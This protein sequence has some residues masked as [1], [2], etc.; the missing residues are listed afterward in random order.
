[1]S[2]AYNFEV[3]GERQR[4]CKIIFQKTLDVGEKAVSYALKNKSGT[5][6]SSVHKRARKAPQNKTPTQTVDDIK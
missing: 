1:M 5:S 4:V 2:R 3:N 6:F